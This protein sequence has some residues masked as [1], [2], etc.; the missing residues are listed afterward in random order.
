MVHRTEILGKVLQHMAENTRDI[1]KKV[2]E[3][4]QTWAEQVGIK[5]MHN[6]QEM[7]QR[8]PKGEVMQTM[9]GHSGA[10][11]NMVSRFEELVKNI[12]QVETDQEQHRA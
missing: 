12:T 11:Q 10:V 4:I 8:L 7:D 6:F 2:T 3:D 1:N 9:L 5:L